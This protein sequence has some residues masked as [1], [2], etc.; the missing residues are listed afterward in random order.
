[1]R[2]CPSFVA[3]FRS[4]G[5]YETPYT[6][7]RVEWFV[8]YYPIRAHM[9]RVPNHTSASRLV[10]PSGSRWKSVFE[11]PILQWQARV[12]T[13]L[14]HQSRAMSALTPRADMVAIEDLRPLCATNGRE[15]LLQERPHRWILSARLLPEPHLLAD[16]HEANGTH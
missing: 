10:R 1:M 5:P 7:R 11:I 9:T 3:Y 15:Q 14:S 4:P 2:S 8:A 6:S 13:G 16:I 12:R